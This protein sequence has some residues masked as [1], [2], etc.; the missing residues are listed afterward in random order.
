MAR[1]ARPWFWEQRGQWAVTID[2]ERHLLGPDKDAAVTEFHRLMSDPNRNVPSDAVAAIIDKFLSWLDKNREKTTYD[3]YRNHLQSFLNHLKPKL[4]PINR[5]TPEHVE[6]WVDDMNGGNSHKRNAITAITGC[7]NWAAKKK[8]IP[9][10]PLKGRLEKKP[11]GRREVVLTQAQY[12]QLLSHASKH[13]KDVLKVAWQTGC[14]PQ[15]IG[16]VEARHVDLEAG[17]WVFPKEESKGKKEQRVV[18]L[19]DEAL[20]ITKERMEKFPEG[21]LFRTQKGNPWDRCNMSET[22]KK[23]QAKT[24]KRFCLYN[25]RHTYITNGL[26]RGVDPVT[27]ATLVGHKDMTMIQRIYSHISQDTE[28]MRKMAAKAFQ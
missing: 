24:G 19:S 1:R 23:L 13:F 27:M 5:L 11:V 16:R 14:R 7:L 25:I 15:E 17:R 2:G 26:K 12:D 10:N 21:P 18:Y 4:L 6:S 20:K 22:F 9:E 28:H 8:H 3:W